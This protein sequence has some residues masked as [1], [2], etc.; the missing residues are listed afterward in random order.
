MKNQLAQIIQD[1]GYDFISA[2]EITSGIINDL[3]SYT[4]GTYTFN[5]DKTTIKVKKT[6]GSAK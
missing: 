6:Q 1:E 5:I 3:M 4:P 2:Y